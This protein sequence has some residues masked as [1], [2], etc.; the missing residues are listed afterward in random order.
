MVSTT[1]AVYMGKNSS[2]N[3]DRS[4]GIDGVEYVCFDG[5][6]AFSPTSCIRRERR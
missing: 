6:R 3:N 2:K 1:K 4:G 5:I